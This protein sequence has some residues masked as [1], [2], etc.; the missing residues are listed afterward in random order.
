MGQSPFAK[1]SSALGSPINRRRSTRIEYVVPIAISG[2]DATGQA[3]REE[4]ETIMVS[5]HGANFRSRSRVL[6]G[7]QLTVENLL[8][9]QS[10]KAICI[11]VTPQE[12]AEDRQV[13]AIQL[14]IPRN[15]WGT[16]DPPAD[17][18]HAM[19]ADS[20]VP[21]PPA[22]ALSLASASATRSSR[23]EAP[24]IDGLD[25]RVAE[26]T[27][28]ALQDL[29]RQAALIAQETLREFESCLKALEA[30]VETR[31][32]QRAEN[33]SSDAERSLDHLL[34][35][36]LEQLTARSNQVAAD[37]EEDLRRRI[38]ELFS[39]LLKMASAAYPEKKEGAE[40]KK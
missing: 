9:S 34:Y 22:E 27:E 6:I 5:A 21:P 26:I 19:V 32:A 4:T 1:S 25:R 35:E 11:R 20:P 3:F 15:I 13:V 2:R 39:P 10:E 28:S 30:G 24:L 36:F 38:S 40:I 31:M 7:M 14:V 37:A 29:R 18:R 8:D 17:W 16:K 23:A 33:T 12:N